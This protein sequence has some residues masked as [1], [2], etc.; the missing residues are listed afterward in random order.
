M[1]PWKP[2]YCMFVMLKNQASS[3]PPQYDNIY[4]II[5][6][7]TEIYAKGLNSLFAGGLSDP[8]V[9]IGSLQ[10]GF[11]KSESA[12]WEGCKLIIEILKAVRFWCNLQSLAVDCDRVGS[13]HLSAARLAWP[14]VFPQRWLPLL[15]SKIKQ[16]INVCSVH[17]QMPDT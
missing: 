1:P 5:V 4:L 8:C 11:V 2:N 14:R 10:F 12:L 16:R 15:R 6:I 13:L 17:M 9:T 7:F 3:N